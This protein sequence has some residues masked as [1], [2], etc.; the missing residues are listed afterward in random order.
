MKKL[1]SLKD[2]ENL[3]DKLKDQ[4]FMRN[5]ADNEHKIVIKVAMGTC[6][7]AA[8][9]RE[10]F[11]VLIE[12]IEN[13]KLDNVIINQTGCMGY[14]HSEP[15]VEI[16]EAG[17]DTILYGNITKEIAAEVIEK[18]ILKGELL[19]DSIIGETH[20]RADEE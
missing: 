7:I 14:C 6:G 15:T 16:S 2:L 8:G 1:G 10:V 11:N 20:F 18:H 5:N 17:K 9:A 4:Y 13:K 3:K 19:Q 12:E